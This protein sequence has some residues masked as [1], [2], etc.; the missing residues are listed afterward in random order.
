MLD[1]QQGV[2]CRDNPV[3]VGIETVQ[4]GRSLLSSDESIII[5]SAIE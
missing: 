5:V 3:T 4:V 2:N 1:D